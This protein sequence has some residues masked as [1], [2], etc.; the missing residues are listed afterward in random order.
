MGRAAWCLGERTARLRPRFCW[1]GLAAAARDLRVA[2]EGAGHANTSHT[3]DGACSLARCQAQLTSGE[4]TRH[5]QHTLVRLCPEIAYICPAGR[6]QRMPSISAPSVLYTAVLCVPAQV[7]IGCSCGPH[8]ALLRLM[9]SS[10]VA[11]ARVMTTHAAV[12][13]AAS[14]GL[15]KCGHSA[16][17]ASYKAGRARACK[18]QCRTLSPDVPMTLMSAR[19]I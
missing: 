15:Q 14:T 11:K 8:V 16:S 13:S 2:M 5:K 4:Q 18:S 19:R 10:V 1:S 3:A 17:D 6:Q 9:S 12:T 7:V